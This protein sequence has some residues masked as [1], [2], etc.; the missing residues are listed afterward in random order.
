LDLNTNFS[1]VL[2]RD[3][4]VDPN[5]DALTYSVSTLPKWLSFDVQ[6]LAFNGTP[7]EYGI[8]NINLTARDGWNASAT[9]GFEIVA[10][11]KPNHPPVVTN[12]L[13]PQLAFVKELFFY[14]FPTDAFSDPD[15]QDTLFYLVS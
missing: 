8:Y 11:I 2:D 1:L 3:T 5:G 4:F 14:K 9:M 6:R 7:T 15:D 12:A 13:Q 10:G